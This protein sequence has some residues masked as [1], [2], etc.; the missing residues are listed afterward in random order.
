MV[1]L[2]LPPTS[3]RT[4]V[5]GKRAVTSGVLRTYVGLPPTI[6]YTLFSD[7]FCDRQHWHHKQNSLSQFADDIVQWT[8][9]RPI[10]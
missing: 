2:A 1:N 5:G 9:A 7:K 3:V 10:G 4:R 6:T 8:F